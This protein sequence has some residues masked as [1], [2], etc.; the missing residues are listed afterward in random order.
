MNEYIFE[1]K[2]LQ[3]YLGET[4][5][6]ALKSYNVII[7][8]GTITSLFTNKEINDIDIYF[9]SKLDLSNFLLEEM[10]GKWV[11]AK[12]DKA[13][14][15]KYNKIKVQAIYFKYFDNVDEIFNTFD[16]TVCMGAYDFTV[17]DFI[18]HKDFLK[19][20][21]QRIL[22]F[23]QNTAYPIVSALRVDKYK[24]KGYY[25]SKAEF[26]RIMLT[27]LQFNITDYKTLKEQMGGMYGENY[28]ALLEP[29]EDEDF[30]LM[31]IIDKMKDISVDDKYFARSQFLVDVGDWEECVLKTLG[32]KFRCFK[33]NNNYYKVV[34]GEVK[35][36]KDYNEENYNLVDVSEIV[37]FPLIRY[38]Y[39]RK[40]LHS[41][42]DKNFIY[43]V[44]EYNEAKSTYKGI[45]AV[46]K[47]KL[48]GCSY[49]SERD[50]I[51]LEL[52]ID[53]VDDIFD[54]TELLDNSASYKRVYATKIISKE[55][56]KEMRD[57]SNDDGLDFWN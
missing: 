12:T 7:A 39:V 47:D 11:I 48:N 45:C 13:F 25:I 24:K 21:S 2:K 36:C 56:E 1:K 42:Y 31:T 30:D 57:N 37:K 35:K 54:M 38:K 50:N 3:S 15:F 16:F 4:L 29:K 8:G 22:K 43:K 33:F 46:T 28:D 40:D 44:N 5:Y 10:N 23:N 14:L 53:S 41:Y 20:N 49:S 34:S 51:L 27:I 17:E 55:E 26:I 6:N 19:H 9:R 52:R 32:E 18:L